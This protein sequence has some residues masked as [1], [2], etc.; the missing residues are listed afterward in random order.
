MITKIRRLWNYDSD[1]KMI[2][3][4]SFYLS[5]Y[6]EFNLAF[7]KFKPIQ[8]LYINSEEEQIISKKKLGILLNARKANSLLKKYAPWRPKCYNLALTTKHL[9]KKKD[10]TTTLHI[11]FRKKNQ[12][13]DGHA[14]L[15]HGKIIVSGYI[16]DLKDFNEMTLLSKESHESVISSL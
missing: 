3:W 1:L 7:K 14:W 4:Q 13:M 12:K 10:I 15:S 5:M 11:G 8:H 16:P 2:L 9:L 6:Y